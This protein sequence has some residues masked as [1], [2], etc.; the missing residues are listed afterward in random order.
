M[1]TILVLSDFSA[2][3]EHAALYASRLAIL[4]KA[5]LHLLH[6]YQVPVSVNELPVLMSPA[7][8]LRKNAEISLGKLREVLQANVPAVE[9]S[10]ESRL[11][12]L[13]DEMSDVA[14]QTDP[15]FIVLGKHQNT[16]AE[17]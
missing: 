17:R 3:A 14:R 4:L 10:L 12:D 15:L 5:K 9:V 13:S 11:G 2:T 7:D 6:V 1:K 16:G 8:E